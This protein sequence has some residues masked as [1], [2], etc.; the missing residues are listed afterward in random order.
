MYDLYLILREDNN[1]KKKSTKKSIKRLKI[2]RKGFL[3]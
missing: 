1:K 2:K 3:L